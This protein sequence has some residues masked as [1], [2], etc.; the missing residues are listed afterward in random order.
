MADIVSRIPFPLSGGET[1]GTGTGSYQLQDNIY[2]FALGGIAFLSAIRDKGDVQFPHKEQMIPIRKQQFDA[3]TE[4]GEQS[5]TD[6][7]FRSQ[8]SFNGGAG[9]L[10]QDP[11]VDNQFGQKFADSLGVDPWAVG[12][13][14]LLRQ[15]NSIANVTTGPNF[16]KGYVN[17]SGLDR[18]WYTEGVLFNSTDGTSTS[19]IG[20]GS[21]AA[22]L[23]LAGAGARYLLLRTDGIWS[24][25]DTGVQTKMYSPPAGTINTGTIG[26]AKDR[27]V[28]AFNNAIYVAPI[29]TT[30]L[31]AALPSVSY[32]HSDPL[33]RW[34]SVTEGPSAIYAAG[35]NGTTSSIFRLSLDLN[36]GSPTL[37]VTVTASFPTGEVIRTIFGYVGSFMGIATNKGFRVGEFTG[38]GDV[39][40]GPLLFT[41]TGGCQGITGFDRFML[42]GSTN[43]HDGSSGLYRIDLGTA[44]QD[45]TSRAVRYAYAR[46]IYGTGD[47]NAIT[48]LDMFGATDQK[49]FITADNVWLEHATDLYPEGYLKTGRIRFNTEE[50]KLFKFVS[51]RAPIP[52][53]GDLALSVLDQNGGETPY[54]T[55]GTGLSPGGKD[56][57]IP[58]PSGPQVWIALKFTLRRGDSDPTV[59][60][61][62]NG[63]QI[64][65]LPGSIRQRFIT[66]TFLLFDEEMDKSGQRIGY[67]GYARE[68]YDQF[69]AL[70]RA[71]DVV[72][73]QLLHD[74]LAI[75][76]V[77]DDWEFT[78]LSPPG[79]NGN[80]LGGYLTVKLR[81]VTETT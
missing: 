11:D 32:T 20:G 63:W 26:Y 48:G 12:E 61:K 8:S 42:T 24:N 37:L 2:D 81:T 30:G 10:Y 22:I 13:L 54:L 5:L 31:P 38:D 28:A 45:Q 29:V 77:I 75:Q 9:L 25:T 21:G 43:Q 50:P 36:A 14:H 7:W 15:A 3:Q 51:L 72:T 52:L 34:V 39:A 16:I 46:G 80:T 60:G 76:V 6:W 78:Q 66:T 62:L 57:G 58:V 18:A 49:I 47:S 40:Y 68:R 33:W 69:K 4:P 23:G 17:T 74:S 55:Y 65:A 70:A 59:G 64:K 41:P 67:R 27:I 56:I 19:A 71:G 1:P 53:E 35:T 79:A 44:V 73:F